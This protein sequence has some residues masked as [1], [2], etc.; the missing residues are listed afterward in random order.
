MIDRYKIKDCKFTKKEWKSLKKAIEKN[1]YKLPKDICYKCKYWEQ[2]CNVINVGGHC[3]LKNEDTLF[4]YGC[5]DWEY[6][7]DKKTGYGF[8]LHTGKI[9]MITENDFLE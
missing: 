4:E 1:K 9:I 3:H 2:F 5:D 8:R 6:V 7:I